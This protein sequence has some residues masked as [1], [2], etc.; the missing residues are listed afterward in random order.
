MKALRK[1]VAAFLLSVTLAA[2]SADLLSSHDYATQFRLEPNALPSRRFPLGTD[3]L[4]RDRFSRLLHGMRCSILLAPAAALVSTLIAVSVG[5]FAGFFGGWVEQVCLSFT[6]LFLVVPWLFLLIT[7]R[8]MLPLNVSP[9]TSVTVT[10]LMLGLLGWSQGG[11]V[12][13]AAAAAIRSSEYLLQAR[14]Y[15]CSDIRLVLVHMLPNLRP[16]LVA[17]FWLLV[18]RFLLTEANLGL[19]GLGVTEPFPS[20]G[21][22]LAELERN[23]QNIYQAPWVLTPAVLLALVVASLHLVISEAKSWQ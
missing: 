1:I 21:N 22:L 2:V 18:P 6:D 17:Q 3:E 8:A 9:W 15:G 14:A 13:R 11:R 19:L 16:I 5:L 12:V 10:F 4:G 20:W 7:L 23:Y